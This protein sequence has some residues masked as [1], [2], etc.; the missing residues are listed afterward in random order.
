MHVTPIKSIKSTKTVN[1]RLESRDIVLEMLHIYPNNPSFQYFISPGQA[2][3]LV[4]M[5]GCAAG[6]SVCSACS[7]GSFS[8]ATGGVLTPKQKQHP[9]C[10]LFTGLHTIRF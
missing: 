5:N 9:F 10:L 8:N 4:D 7:A 6:A 1:N 2:N 3:D